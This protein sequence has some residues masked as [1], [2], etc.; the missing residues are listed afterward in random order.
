MRPHYSLLWHNTWIGPCGID[1][2]EKQ[3]VIQFGEGWE[4]YSESGPCGPRVGQELTFGFA[5]NGETNKSKSVNLQ[6]TIDGQLAGFS[7]W[8]IAKC[9]KDTGL[10]WDALELIQN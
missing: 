7:T 9:D 4:T 6:V 8:F 5:V 1:F 3:D 2:F 10:H